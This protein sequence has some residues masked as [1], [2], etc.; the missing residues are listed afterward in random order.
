MSFVEL[1]NKVPKGQKENYTFIESFEQLL[2]TQSELFSNFNDLLSNRT[3]SNWS[4]EMTPEDQVNFLNSYEDLLRRE[5]NLFGDFEQKLNDSWS[6]FGGDYYYDPD[7]PGV[8]PQHTAAAQR[9][10]LTSLEDLLRRQEK[11]YGGF[12]NLEVGLDKNVSHED[13]VK[14]LSSFEDLLRR[15]SKL[16]SSFEDLIKM[17]FNSTKTD[18]LNY[19]PTKSDSIPVCQWCSD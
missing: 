15:E 14:F 3:T 2:R 9:E 10:L 18:S 6:T 8:I 4:K 1:L 16:L 5:A 13:R 19:N 7:G 17:N 12:S 11:L